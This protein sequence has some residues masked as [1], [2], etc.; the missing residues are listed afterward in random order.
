MAPPSSSRFLDSEAVEFS[1]YPDKRSYGYTF[2]FPIGPGNYMWTMNPWIVANA[3]GCQVRKLVGPLLDER[4]GLGFPLQPEFFE[5]DS[6]Y[7][8]E[9]VGMAEVRTGSRLIPRKN[10]EDEG[11]LN[12]TIRT[13]RELAQEG[14][15]LIHYNINAAAP[16]GTPNSAANPA[17]GDAVIFVITAE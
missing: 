3:S 16:D 1:E 14:A 5:Y 12:D 6:F 7:P 2:I 11:L 17:W 10:W 9:T 8:A 13:L 15:T 4:A